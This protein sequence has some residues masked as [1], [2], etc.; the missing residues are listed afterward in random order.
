MTEEEIEFP[1]GFPVYEATPGESVDF[2]F[3]GDDPAGESKPIPL[4]ARIMA[5][6]FTTLVLWAGS[7]QARLA[8]V[9]KLANLDDRTQAQIARA[10]RISEDKINRAV[11]EGEAFI[12]TAVRELTNTI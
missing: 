9:P 10:H 12:K 6:R 7:N 1:G 11:R 5:A 2:A 3:P 8:V 4:D